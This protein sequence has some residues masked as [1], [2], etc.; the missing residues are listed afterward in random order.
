MGVRSFRFFFG[1]KIIK[2][3]RPNNDTGINI[4][5]DGK[6]VLEGIFKSFNERYLVENRDVNSDTKKISYTKMELFYF[7]FKN[8]K[9]MDFTP[10]GTHH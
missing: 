8:S 9:V 2:E 10:L 1:N 4:W 3:T 5:S 7:E 6:L